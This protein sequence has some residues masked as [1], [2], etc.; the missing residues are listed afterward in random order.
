VLGSGT[1]LVGVPLSFGYAWSARPR[2]PRGWA[3]RLAC[4]LSA[5]ALGGLVLLAVLT[6]WQ[7]FD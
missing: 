7:K 1:V 3:I 5:V 2:V 4:G 6:T